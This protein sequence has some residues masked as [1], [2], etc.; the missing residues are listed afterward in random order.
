MALTQPHPYAACVLANSHD[1]TRIASAHTTAQG[2]LPAEL[3]AV[4]EAGEKAHGATAYLNLEPGNYD[5]D[6]LAVSALIQAGVVRAVIGLLH[7]L[8][9]L[10]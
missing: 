8:A 4:R 6:N 1:G 9:H 2:T 10:R 5:A 3:L 7:P